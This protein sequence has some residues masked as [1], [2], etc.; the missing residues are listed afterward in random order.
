MWRT[1]VNI[2]IIPVKGHILAYSYESLLFDRYKV[3]NGRI[4]LSTGMC[5]EDKGYYEIHCF[6]EMNEYRFLSDDGKTNEFVLSAGEETDDAD[7]FVYTEK[8][9]I[10]DR[11]M[12]D[13]NRAYL[14]V[15]NRFKFSEDDAI[16]LNDYRLA[17]VINE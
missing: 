15:V 9:L 10:Q 14:T 4:V 6:D 16:Y 17:G 8:Q 2:E 11:Y 3:E 12:E 7:S 13:N 5:F 1:T